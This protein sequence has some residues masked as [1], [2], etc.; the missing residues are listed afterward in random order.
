MDRTKQHGPIIEIDRIRA[1]RSR[2]AMQAL[3]AHADLLST[4]NENSSLTLVGQQG[5]SSLAGAGGCDSVFNQMA[6]KV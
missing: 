5:G 4:S 3:D 2:Q 6:E 1:Q